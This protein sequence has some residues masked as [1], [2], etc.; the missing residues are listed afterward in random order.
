MG[1]FDYDGDAGAIPFMVG[2]A[3]GQIQVRMRR[4]RFF[5]LLVVEV[6]RAG[7]YRTRGWTLV[8]VGG[9]HVAVVKAWATRTTSVPS[10]SVLVA[11]E[12][13]LPEEPTITRMTIAITIANS[14]TSVLPVNLPKQPRGLS[15]DPIT[16]SV[17]SQYL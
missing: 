10:L 15:N 7:R 12:G 9:A 5:F 17:K 6:L 11:V 3:G 8:T 4:L 1:D 16:E 14:L 13:R 2:S